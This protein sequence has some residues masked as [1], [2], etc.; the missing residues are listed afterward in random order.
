MAY[1]KLTNADEVDII[2]GSFG[3]VIALFGGT[4]LSMLLHKND[5]IRKVLFG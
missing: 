4:L 1:C 5:F 2:G 3:I